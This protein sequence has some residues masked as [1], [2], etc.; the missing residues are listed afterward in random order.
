MR[1]SSGP[2]GNTSVHARRLQSSTSAPGLPQHAC[3]AT[4]RARAGCSWGF[5][6]CLPHTTLFTYGLRR[7][8]AFLISLPYT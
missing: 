4:P 5:S 8:L 7:A 1:G 2:Q 6:V 3:S